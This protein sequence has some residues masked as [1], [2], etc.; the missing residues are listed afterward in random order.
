[1]PPPQL[2][3]LSS[4]EDGEI[5]DVQV[6]TNNSRQLQRT[7]EWENRDVI[8]KEQHKMEEEEEAGRINFTIELEASMK[9]KAFF[10]ENCSAA[11]LLADAT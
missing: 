5:K 7:R 4:E 10:A 8:V 11:S 6:P 2:L 3:D 9:N 1:M